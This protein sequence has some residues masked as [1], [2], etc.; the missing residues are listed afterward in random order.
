MGNFRHYL[1]L[2]E[3]Y[4]DEN[5]YL[6]NYMRDSE[7]DPY[8]QW[9]WVCEW[10][11]EHGYLNT[12]RTAMRKTG[13]GTAD[14]PK[15]ASDLEDFE[16]EWFQYLPKEAQKECANSVVEHLMQNDP[17]QA[18]SWAHMSL[19][20]Q[21]LLPRQ[22]WLAHFT[23]DPWSIAS[24]GFKYGMMDV[25]RLGLTTYFKNTG[26]SKKYGGYNFAFI[27]DSKDARW[28]ASKHK[29]GKDCVLFQNS[30]ILV[31]HHGDQENQVIFRGSDVDPREII[32]LKY[33]GDDWI[34]K[35]H[36][37]TR[38][39]SDDL[40][41]GSFEACVAWVKKN[42]NQYRKYLVKK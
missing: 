21:Q 12:I 39:Q 29:Y 31:D 6:R 17:A 25:D 35:G 7:F 10:I 14:L 20:K 37:D 16:A 4:S 15:S 9:Y 40:F 23:D 28:A 36:V 34:V 42:Y 27:A 3:K 13:I 1:H 41:K 2:V 11:E 30:G 33:D 18:P 5:G 8:A 38:R 26:D 24:S 22:T 19:Q 32:V